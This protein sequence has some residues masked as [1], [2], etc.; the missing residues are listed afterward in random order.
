MVKWKISKWSIKPITSHL[1]FYNTYLLHD[2][3]KFNLLALTSTLKTLWKAFGGK[4]KLDSAVESSGFQIFVGLETMSSGIWRNDL[5]WWRTVLSW[6]L[7]TLNQSYSYMSNFW[8]LNYHYDL[9]IIN[10]MSND[11]IMIIIRSRTRIIRVRYLTPNLEAM[12]VMCRS[13]RKK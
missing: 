5:S 2:W 12:A 9:S 7:V 8:R 11:D 10:S 13:I 6:M 1:M 3:M 4:L